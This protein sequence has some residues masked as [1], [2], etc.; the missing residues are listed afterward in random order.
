M[1]TELEIGKYEEVQT[2]SQMALFVVL[3]KMQL[4]QRFFMLVLVLWQSGHK[5]KRAKEFLFQMMGVIL[6]V[7]YHL[8]MINSNTHTKWLW[9]KIVTFMLPPYLKPH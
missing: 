1:I 4:I 9:V 7:Y 6:G 2:N 8:L 5:Q 3:F